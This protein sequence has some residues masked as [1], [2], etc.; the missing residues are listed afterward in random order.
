MSIA[1]ISKAI[2]LTSLCCAALPEFARAQSVVVRHSVVAEVVPVIG[3]RDSSWSDRSDVDGSTRTTWSGEIRANAISEVQVLG[4]GDPEP[5]YARTNAGAW[6]RLAAGV[7]NTVVVTP[8]GRRV[9][10]MEVLV[11]THGA[12]SPKLPAVR[13]VAR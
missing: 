6:Q 12:V 13:I 5:A 3:V 7:W 9:V 10:T 1:A 2:C 8:A 4:P 11:A